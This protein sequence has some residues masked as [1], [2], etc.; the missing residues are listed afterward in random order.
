MPNP[1]LSSEQKSRPNLPGGGSK[2][3]LRLSAKVRRFAPPILS[4]LASPDADRPCLNFKQDGLP[5]ATTA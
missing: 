1:Y 4:K 2:C 5:A 3:P